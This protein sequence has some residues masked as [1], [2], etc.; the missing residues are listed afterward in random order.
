MVLSLYVPCDR[1]TMQPPVHLGKLTLGMTDPAA[2]NQHMLASYSVAPASTAEITDTNT[3]FRFDGTRWSNL[4][5][6][7]GNVYTAA[8]INGHGDLVTCLGTETAKTW[9]YKNCVFDLRGTPLDQQD[10][11]F[12]V[13]QGAHASLENCVFLG[14]KKAILCGS[15]DS[16][17]WGGSLT[18]KNCVVIGCGRRMPEAQQ[19]YTVT[20]NGCWLHNWGIEETFD[21]RTFAVW[22][23]DSATADVTGCV[24]TRNTG[25]GGNSDKDIAEWIGWYTNEFGALQAL[26]KERY[27]VSGSLRAIERIGGGSFT[28]SNNYRNQS[29]FVAGGDTC[30]SMNAEGARAQI[31][32][33][34]RVCPDMAPYLGKSLL[35]YWIDAF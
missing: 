7:T 35:Q 11:M 4:G 34:N 13:V 12:S 24:F 14:G 18:M 28:A 19:G 25:L 22:V 10:E 29:D 30:W 1:G 15:G 26:G 17:D 20:M 33:L 9:N 27:G 32:V 6:I 3:F 16:G 21:V 5:Y 2:I 23:H 8:D 31:E